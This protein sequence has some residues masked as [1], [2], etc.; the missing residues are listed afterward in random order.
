[1]I[2]GIRSDTLSSALYARFLTVYAI[3]VVLCILAAF[4]R[5]GRKDADR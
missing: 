1:M 2:F 5:S 4:V 3:D